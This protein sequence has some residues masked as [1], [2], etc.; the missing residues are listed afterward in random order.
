MEAEATFTIQQVAAS[1]FFLYLC[2]SPRII[3]SS[4]D[5]VLS[6]PLT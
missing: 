3:A 2:T 5:L 4:V 6:H 1:A